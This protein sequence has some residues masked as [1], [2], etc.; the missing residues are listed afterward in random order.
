MFGQVSRL[1]RH[2]FFTVDAINF[3]QRLGSGGQ[4]GSTLFRP[5]LF[6]RGKP[7]KTLDE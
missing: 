1:A 2:Q 6:M 3:A 5:P 4:T 7:R